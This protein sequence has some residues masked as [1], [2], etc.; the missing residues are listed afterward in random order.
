MIH[1]DTK[2][3]WA[4]AH[5]LWSKPRIVENWLNRLEFS[6]N[7]Q[8]SEIKTVIIQNYVVMGMK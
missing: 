6:R 2:P 8:T 3:T 4:V 5:E 1:Y 7:E